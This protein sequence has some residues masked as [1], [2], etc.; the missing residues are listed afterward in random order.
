MIFSSKDYGVD[1]LQFITT[2]PDTVV[3]ESN[4]CFKVTSTGYIVSEQINDMDALIIQH[5]QHIT[6]LEQQL[7][8][9]QIQ[10][11]DLHAAWIASQ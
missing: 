5:Q 1:Y 11:D 4:I 3:Q 7:E 9:L 6:S 2:G 8:T 10:F